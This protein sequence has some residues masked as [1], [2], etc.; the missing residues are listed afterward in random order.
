MVLSYRA[1]LIF[2]SASYIAAAR[3]KMPH[4]RACTRYARRPHCKLNC[5]DLSNL[6]IQSF[7]L[8]HAG[9]MASVERF[10][11]HAPQSIRGGK[12]EKAGDH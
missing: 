4:S 6:R 8:S 3:V 1:A 5:Y 12:L 11:C 9:W 2:S 7:F 10:D